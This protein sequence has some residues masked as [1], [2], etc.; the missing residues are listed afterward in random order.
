[1]KT[2]N[3]S[4]NV[5]TDGNIPTNLQ[6]ILDATQSDPFSVLGLHQAA[7][8]T[9]IRVHIPFAKKVWILDPDQ[10]MKRLFNSDLFEWRV[11]A[12]LELPHHYLVEW[13]D[14]S[15]RHH[16]SIDP[17]S[18]T[19]L[20]PEFDIGL[21]QQ[22]K[23]LHI[24]NHL[25]AHIRSIDGIS[26]VTFA[27]WA[28]NASRVSVI[29][30]F[31]HWD[32]RR[33]PMRNRG[34]S[35]IWEIFIPHLPAEIAY[36]YEIR[37]QHGDLFEKADPYAQGSEL[38][39]KTASLI[40]SQTTYSW[41]DA[42]WIDRR[43]QADW[44]HEPMSVYEVHLGSWRRNRDNEF[45][46]YHELAKEL[47]GYVKQMGYSH[48]QLLP[49]TE[50]PLDAS[51][52]YQTTGYFTP[53]SRF[54][55]PDEFRYF[56]DFCHQND[57]SVLLDWVPAHFPKD[58]H[59]LARFDGSALY[60]HED[61]RKGEHRDWGTH[62]YNYGRNEVRNFLLSSA[63]FW[64]EE[65]HI[66][67]L[68]VDAVASMLYLDYSREEGDWEANIYGGNENLEAI[69]FIRELNTVIHERFPGSLV[70]AEES[71]SWPQVTRPVYVGGLGFSMKWNMGWMHDTL[72][73]FSK[74][75]VHR[76]YHHDQLTFGLLYAFTENFVL[77]FSHDEVVHG[78]SSM[79]NK[80]PGDEWQKF[81]NLRLLYSYMFTYPG[82]KILFMGNDIAQGSEWDFDQQ[83]EWYVLDY[84]LHQGVQRLVRDLNN[85]YRTHS[86]LYYYDFDHTGFEWI[87]CNDAEQSVISYM[88][89]R[90]NEFLLVIHN[91]TPKPRHTYTI[92]VP[93]PG[94]YKEIL[95]SDSE[96]Y[97][98][99]NMGNL[100]AIVSQENHWQP[101]THS[102][103]L[104]LPPLST[105]VLQRES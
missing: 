59:A 44:L 102:I 21:F 41:H 7:D 34:I 61:P 18:F 5:H 46:N 87:D 48:I 15:N 64:M 25:G 73:Y 58:G 79:L 11:P 57:I 84:P 66:D 70:I 78:K 83:V 50:H 23:H 51:W 72:V 68:R 19:T 53:T 86:A 93:I 22:G 75:P 26:G 91:F 56:V 35:G 36:K 65:F 99:S 74:D 89:Q 4:V 69:E 82:K 29:G 81:A 98:G 92:R 14:S 101:G 16:Q 13:I 20:I 95:N 9:Y 88:R 31:N 43:Q 8:H 100:G 2:P 105:I 6:A 1:M 85:L 60:E 49:V 77:P 67:G 47:V 52:G 24:Y 32:G 63:V 45:L 76:H 17:Y 62:I 37:S 38:R 28:P 96:Y 39:P 103:N 12:K 97:H 55:S 54:G 71:T 33:Y 104:T 94:Q 27:I 30:D 3:K 10:P 90:D 40:K 80:M 42:D